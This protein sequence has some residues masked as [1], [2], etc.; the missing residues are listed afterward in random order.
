MFGLKSLLIDAAI[1][2]QVYVTLFV[3]LHDWVPLGRFNDVKAVRASEPAGRLT[4]VTI[5]S[6]LPFAF[7]AAESAVHASGLPGWLMIFLWIS[8]GVAA[9]G[10]LRTWWA[11]YLLFKEPVRATH[12]QAMHGRT[13]AFLPLHNGMRPNTLHVTV[14][15]AILAMLADLAML[16]FGFAGR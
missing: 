9:Y 7:G 13:H 12:Y 5:L 6:T 10:L 1:T 15:L 16:T 3:A 8:Y 14:H 4:A 2:L 11:P